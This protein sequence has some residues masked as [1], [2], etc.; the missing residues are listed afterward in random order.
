VWD[1]ADADHQAAGS[2]GKV[3]SDIQAKT[4]NLP[5]SPAPA[6][7]YDTEMARIT[8]DVATE[9][10]QDIIES[11]ITALNDISVANILAGTI[12][13][14]ITVKKA[15]AIVMAFVA[16]LTSGGG[17]TEIIFKNQADDTN[18]IKMTVDADGDRSSITIDTSDL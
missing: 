3:I 4:D 6:S 12:E 16:G 18:R 1:E 15:L 17:T 13:G 14:S 8:A 7:E 10:K 2:K 5:A 11:A 9:A